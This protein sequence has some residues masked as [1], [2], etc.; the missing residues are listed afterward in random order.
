VFRS[1][2]LTVLDWIYTSR[3]VPALCGAAWVLHIR[4]RFQRRHMSFFWPCPVI[5]KPARWQDAL[6]T[7]GSIDSSPIL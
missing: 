2:F 1:C 7:I 5:C 3:A 6:I 4:W